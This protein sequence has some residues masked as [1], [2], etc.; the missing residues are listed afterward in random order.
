MTLLAHLRYSLADCKPKV[1]P[2]I[3]IIWLNKAIFYT[4]NSLIL[5][6][7]TDITLFLPIF[8]PNIGLYCL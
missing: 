7:F 6:H 5:S 3:E 4:S 2:L 1:N 8:V